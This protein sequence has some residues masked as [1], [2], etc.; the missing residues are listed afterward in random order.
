[1]SDVLYVRHERNCET[2]RRRAWAT[3]IYLMFRSSCC[4]LPC[5][6]IRIVVAVS[7]ES[8]PAGS[9][10]YVYV[11]MRLTRRAGVQYWAPPMTE[12]TRIVKLGGYAAASY[13]YPLACHP[14]SIYAA[15]FLDDRRRSFPSNSAG[16]YMIPRANLTISS[17]FYE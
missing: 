7:Y 2:G 9:E 6:S 8:S 11:L 1:M 13:T 3:R 15:N 4:P 5:Q 14:S 17:L 16:L 10:Y 12:Q